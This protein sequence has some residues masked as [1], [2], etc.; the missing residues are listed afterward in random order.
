MLADTRRGVTSEG[1]G[2]DESGR[3]DQQDL[4][5]RLTYLSGCRKNMAL[6]LGIFAQLP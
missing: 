6:Q 2:N 5:S 3:G 1:S 4:A